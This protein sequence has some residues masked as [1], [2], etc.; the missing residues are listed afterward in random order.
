MR[1]FFLFLFF[2][3]PLMPVFVEAQNESGIK[4]K[5]TDSAK[6]PLAGLN[7]MLLAANDSAE[8]AKALTTRDGVFRFTGVAPG[9]YLVS[10]EGVGYLRV[11]SDPFEYQG[12]DLM[13]P[14]LAV[15]PQVRSMEEVKVV[16][17]KQ[18]FE[19]KADRIVVNVEAAP[20]N[21]GANILE[22]LEKSP[23]VTVDRDGNIGLK[24]KPGAQVYV[25]GK[26]TYLSG[27][28]LANMLRNMQAAQ[29][30]Q[31]E[32]MTNPSSKYDA[33]G[34][35]GII[36]IR[37][38]K[39]RQKGYNGS[40]TA[41]YTQGRFARTN[42]S[43]QF[44]L[45]NNRVNLFSNLGY[46]R[47]KT[48][49]DLMLERTFRDR[50]TGNT[51]S[52]FI[53][54]S[55]A[56]NRGESF[57]G[58]IGLDY[59]VSK[60]TTLGIAANAFSNPGRFSSLSD[61]NIYDAGMRLA[62]TTEGR[63]SNRERWRNL[64]LNLNLRHLLDSNGR[65][66]TADLDRIRYNGVNDQILSTIYNDALGN[67]IGR[68]DTLLGDL[69]Q[70]IGI[71][72]G[73]FDYVHPLKK[74]AKLEAGLK[75]SFVETDNDARYDSLIDANKVPDVGRSNHFVYRER[76]YAGY[77]NYSRGL[78]KKWSTQLGLR[79]ES[80]IAIGRQ[81]TTGED[82]ERRYTQLFPT[83]FLQ[84]TAGESNVLSMNYGRRIRRPDYA[85][86][87][88]FVT[89][90]DRYTS[91]RGNPNLQP[92]LSQNLEFSHTWK[93]FLTTTLNYNRTREVI[94]QV[95]EQNEATNET[96]A[97]QSNIANQ[98]QYG[99][100]MMAFKQI[101]KFSGNLYAN[102]Y[103]NLFKGVI[104]D[105]A[106]EIG[107]TTLVLSGSTSYRFG[108]GFTAELGGF[109]RTPA[110]E[111]VFQIRSLGVFNLGASKTMLKNKG[112]LTLNL[113]DV[114][115]TQNARGSAK[116]GLVDAT[117]HIFNDSRTV[118]LSFTYRFGKGQTSGGQRRR[119]GAAGD[120]QDRVKSGG[121][122]RP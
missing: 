108:K 100:S 93:G 39:N 14:T 70:T 41:A 35:S 119:T 88:P 37:T 30:D 29:V 26:P 43:V 110:V 34:N 69:P 92:E 109:Y 32:I 71:Q 102:L 17:R 101:G 10:A 56:V 51:L 18:M 61:M 19:Q 23:G 80:T 21:A 60:K 121:G 48:F 107:A 22:V 57:N 33:A 47:R 27:N 111:G 53:Q 85:S 42:E 78:G 105:A 5:L 104:G 6:M 62:G 118:T 1:R 63:L 45:R 7:V 72:S 95:L 40:L 24:G 36:N 44:N 87:N 9:R 2:L 74:G 20:T 115:W 46:N 8:T 116:Y 91:E 28:E 58:K 65:E 68:T 4:G 98:R 66:I 114:L 112:T 83:I 11:F 86:L 73:K 38:K 90:I 82:F 79:L 12:V 67:R 64:G 84:Y 106:V 97:I 117:F 49:S 54:E 25:D 76:I 122:N 59:S 55:N 103:N 13:L 16:S 15:K 75:G 52:H 3:S 77:V 94:Q 99:L 81:L 50:I 120:E 96:Y 113:R 89:F 31:V